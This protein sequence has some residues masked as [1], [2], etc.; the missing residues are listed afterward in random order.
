VHDPAGRWQRQKGQAVVTRVAAEEAQ[1]GRR[2]VRG[3]PHYL[4]RHPHRI[5]QLEAEHVPVEVQRLIV[6]ASGQHHVAQTLI[7]GDELVP[8]RADDPAVFQCGA[9]EDGQRVAGRVGELDHLVHS[10]LRQIGGGGLLVGCALDVEPIPDF[11]QSSGI[12]AFP[13]GLRQP[14]LLTG[15]D[16]QPGREIVHPQIERALGRPVA[17][18]HAEDFQAVVTPGLHIGGRDA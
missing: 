18:D 1:P 4:R 16:H 6:V 7:A 15:H 11:L 12:R 10:P 5:T 13:A 17:L 9:M 2:P 8:V 3:P 14:V